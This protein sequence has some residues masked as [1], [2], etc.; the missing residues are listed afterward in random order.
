MAE[1]VGWRWISVIAALVSLLRLLMVRGTPE[2]KAPPKEGY[3]FDLAGVLTFMVTMVA[4]QIFA[5]QGAGLGWT[6]P[7]SLGLLA[8]SLIFGIAFYRIENGNPNAF[9]QF[10]LFRNLT[11]TG[12]TISN[13]LLNATAGIIMVAMLLLQEGGDLAPTTPQEFHPL[14]KSEYASWAKVIKAAGIVAE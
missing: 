2:S 7:V 11:Y 12:A 1:N 9:V 14:I 10:R 13:L 5:T 4:L 8:A 6:S 3:R